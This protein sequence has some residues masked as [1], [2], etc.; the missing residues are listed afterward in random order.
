LRLLPISSFYRPIENLE[1]WDIPSVA[2]LA[3]NI[4]E[5]YHVFFYIVEGVSEPELEARQTL[6]VSTRPLNG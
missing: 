5:T 4:I 1:V 6:G 2:S 3:R